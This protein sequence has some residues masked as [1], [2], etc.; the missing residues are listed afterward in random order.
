MT[1]AMYDEFKADMYQLEK[2]GIV[3]PLPE[4]MRMK[5]STVDAP[6]YPKPEIPNDR[7]I[8]SNDN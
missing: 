1:D 6:V 5:I 3:K 2:D 7:P 4:E 8:T